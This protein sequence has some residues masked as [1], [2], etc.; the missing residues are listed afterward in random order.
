S[1]IFLLRKM[2]DKKDIGQSQYY[3]VL[4]LYLTISGLWPYYGLRDRWVFFV[5]MFMFCFTILIP[6]RTDMSSR[7][8][9]CLPPTANTNT[10]P[11]RPAYVAS[12]DLHQCQTENRYAYTISEDGKSEREKRGTRGFTVAVYQLLWRATSPVPLIPGEKTCLNIIQKN[13]LSL[14]TDVE[15]I[16]LQR[17]TKYGQYLMTFYAGVYN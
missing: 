5:L 1:A 11:P 7:G 10:F 14:N 2:I 12:D 17:H 16:I 15:K 3:I 8:S 4:K 13:W 6:Q 9:S